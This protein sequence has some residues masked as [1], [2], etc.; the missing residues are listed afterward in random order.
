MNIASGAAPIAASLQPDVTWNN[1]K[2]EV[3][4]MYWMFLG[5]YTLLTVC[6]VVFGRATPP[7]QPDVTDLQVALWYAEHRV[8]IQIGFVLLLA[9][10]G[11]AAIA[12]GIIGYFM[13][14]MSSGKALAYA[15]IGS[16]GVGAL[17]GFQLIALCWLTALY[18]P[19]RSAESM[20]MLYDLGML[21]YNGTAGC[22]TAAYIVL[23]IAILYDKNKIFPKWFAYVQ[24]WQVVT[25][26]LAT[27]MFVFPAGAFSW[28]GAITFWIAVSV[29]GAWVV[30]LL[31]ILR[32]AAK[33]EPADAPGIYADLQGAK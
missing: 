8:V 20:H 10:A 11:G 22:F 31:P 18:R 13:L 1:A 32:K 7:P 14:R 29:F 33:A 21:S 28:N 26:L 23:A 16:M 27:Q 24:L 9:T 25:E 3:R 19:E 2:P 5:F 12:N 6:V 30:F 15:Y 4:L 17:P